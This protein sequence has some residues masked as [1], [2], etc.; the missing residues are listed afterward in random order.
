[1]RVGPQ[2]LCSHRSVLPVCHRP[3]DTRRA[4][5]EIV[6]YPETVFVRQGRYLLVP[7]SRSGSTT[8]V[9]MAQKAAP[10]AGCPRLPSPATRQPP[11]AREQ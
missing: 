4:A 7:I 3:T 1:M 9:V 11:S 5:A 8:E 2:R 10:S 6:F